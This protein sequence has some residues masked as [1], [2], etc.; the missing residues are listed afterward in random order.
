MSCH[1]G[2]LPAKNEFK[3]LILERGPRGEVAHV[4]S[5]KVEIP[6]LGRRDLELAWTY[7]NVIETFGPLGIASACVIQGALAKSNNESV[8]ARAQVEGV[9]LA[10]L[11][12]LKVDVTSL[13]KA[14]LVTE[15]N[16]KRNSPL[17]LIPDLPALRTGNGLQKY[18]DEPLAAALVAANVP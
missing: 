4:S 18:F 6:Q 11:A 3:W 9:V 8:L 13:K 1:L 15:F 2:L 10:A 12:S 14:G 7:A 17:E 5:K 16:L